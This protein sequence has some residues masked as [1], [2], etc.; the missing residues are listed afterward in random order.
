MLS[1]CAERALASSCGVNMNTWFVG[2]H[3]VGHYVFQYRTPKDNEN[4]E[5]KVSADTRTMGEK[6]FLMKARIMAGQ[7]D[8]DSTDAEDFRWLAK[9]EIQKIVTPWYWSNIKNMLVDQ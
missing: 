5:V 2:A 3:P 6:T 7:A 9:E 1:Q 8:V 4:Q